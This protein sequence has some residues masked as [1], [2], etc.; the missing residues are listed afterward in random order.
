MYSTYEQAM[1]EAIKT[2]KSLKD[3]RI[4]VNYNLN[5][6]YYTVTVEYYEE[7]LNEGWDNEPYAVF[8]NGVDIDA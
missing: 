2:S 5:S 8:V 1:N 7:N 3:R 6:G 4:Y